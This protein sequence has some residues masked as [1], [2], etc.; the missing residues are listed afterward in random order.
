LVPLFEL[1]PTTL[2]SV[3]FKDLLRLLAPVVPWARCHPLPF[4]FECWRDMP[5][6]PEIDHGRCEAKRDCVRVCPND[7]FEVRRMDVADFEALGLLGKLRTTAHR[8]MTAY[9]VRA[10]QCEE[11]GK[12]VTACPEGA[13][14][15]IELRAE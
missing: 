11:C 5:T 8:R 4:I 1:D 15:L 13:I 7:V 14:T 6:R 9:A 2:R 3:R 10:G 12:C